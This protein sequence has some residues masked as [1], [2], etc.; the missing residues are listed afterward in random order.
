MKI[1]LE[2]QPLKVREAVGELKELLSFTVVQTAEEADLELLA[3][4][5]ERLDCDIRITKKGGKA[6]L[7][8]SRLSC[9]SRG[10]YLLLAGGDRELNVCQRC[11][12]SELGIMLDCS[13]NAVPNVEAVKDMIRHIAVM[14]YNTL[15]LYTEDTFQVLEEPYFG[16]M[17]GAYTKEEIR[18]IDRYCGIFG[19]A[20]TPCIQCLAHINQIT[21]YE[22]YGEIIDTDDILLVGEER[23]YEFLDHLFSALSQNFTSRKVNIGMDEAHMLGRGK[24]QNRNG[25]RERLPLMLEHLERVT[26]LCRKYGFKPQMWSDMFFR[27]AFGGEYYVDEKEMPK[28]FDRI[29]QDIQLLYWDYYSTDF[30]HYDSMLKKHKELTEQVG[31]AGGA[32]KWTGFAPENDY[33]LASLAPAMDACIGREIQSFLLTCWGDNGAEAGICSVL[34]TIYFCAEK[35]YTG[36][37]GRDAENG[38]YRLTGIRFEDYLKLDLP[39][40]LTGRPGERGNAGKYFLYNDLLLGTF[41]SLVPDGVDGIYEKHA[42]TLRVI[43]E[44]GGRYAALFH[45]LQR[46]CEVLS[47]K[48]G[49]GVRMKKAYDEG[50][51]ETLRE[52][53]HGALPELKIRLEAFYQAF[54]EQWQK[55]NKT[56]GFE[57]QCARLGGLMLRTEYTGEQLRRYL[58]GAAE[59][60]GEL[61]EV[62][63]PFAYFDQAELGKLNY[64]LWSHIISPG[65][66]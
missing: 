37:M 13:R 28:V 41:D 17:R 45:T 64:N 42:E 38:F 65:I 7:A 61:E 9:F 48:A 22:Q 56:F 5:D 62:R 11:A 40:R 6:T 33:S 19:I 34:P 52:I 32:W 55:E 66:V 16:Y 59:E 23:T 58:D 10:L 26:Q 57:V 63:R 60:I 18:E 24:Y 1:Y 47:I 2:P 51:K 49:L 21:R 29:P 43:G 12:F 31:F 8:Y 39:N 50:D 46:L 3:E 36:E 53:L 15:E 54:Y 14:G 4:L 35:A 25:Y 27:L 20:L 44:Q 30:K